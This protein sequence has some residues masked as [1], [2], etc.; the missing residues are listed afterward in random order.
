MS[1]LHRMRKREKKKER[2]MKL[3]SD[4][5]KR[6]GGGKRKR[7]EAI[8]LSILILREKKVRDTGISLRGKKKGMEAPYYRRG[9][10]PTGKGGE[11]SRR[12]KK[13]RGN[14]FSLNREK[15][16]S[17]GERE[18]RGEKRIFS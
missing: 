13:R 14:M 3:P 10:T 1:Q 12:K 6:K 2:D 11:R 9:T 18:G 17:R 7:G 16:K 5:R 4:R 8:P 15:G